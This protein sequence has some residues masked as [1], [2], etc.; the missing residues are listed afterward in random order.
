MRIGRRRLGVG[1]YVLVG[2]T[3]MGRKVFEAK[4]RIVRGKLKGETR[5][6]LLVR[7][8][9]VVNRCAA[10]TLAVAPLIADSPTVRIATASHG[11][12]GAAV[13]PLHGSAPPASRVIRAISLS[14][15]PTPLRSLLLVLLTISISLLS[16]AAIPQRALPTGPVAAL[17]ARRRTHLA[18]AGIW[19]LAIVV[20]VIA[21]E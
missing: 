13:P 9:A 19:L 14:G 21:S 8:G 10:P 12:R 6:T 3:H 1:T 5:R 15:A 18:L 17:F 2:R 11:V 7:R 16:L 4:A 20:I